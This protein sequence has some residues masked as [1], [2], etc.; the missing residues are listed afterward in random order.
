MILF[1]HYSNT[2]PPQN[3]GNLVL[4]TNYQTVKKQNWQIKALLVLD[5]KETI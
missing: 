3:K 4:N 5:P 2:V 1:Y